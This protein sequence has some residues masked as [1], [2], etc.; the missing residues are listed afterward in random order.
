MPS[1]A[2]TRHYK[3]ANCQG[4]SGKEFAARCPSA[5]ENATRTA[6]ESSPVSVWKRDRARPIFAGK[7]RTPAMLGWRD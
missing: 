6:S 2:Q 1:R 7:G 5:R 4:T 3:T